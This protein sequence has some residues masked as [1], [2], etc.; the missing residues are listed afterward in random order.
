ML[1]GFVI[2][3]FSGGKKMELCMKC[4]KE[5]MKEG[6]KEGMKEGHNKEN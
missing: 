4:K 3:S 6:R 1:A 2:D 5:G